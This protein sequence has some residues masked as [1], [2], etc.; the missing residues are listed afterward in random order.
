MEREILP[1]AFS[2][3]AFVLV[4]RPSVVR[5]Q[6]R[7]LLAQEWNIEL[8]GNPDFLDE[9]YES[10]GIDEARTLKE[11][12]VSHGFG[13]NKRVF[14]I[15]FNFI[16]RE[17]QNAL[18]KVFEEPTSDTCFFL[19]TSS[20][21]ALLP[22]LRSR[23]Q[24]M[25]LPENTEGEESGVDPKKFLAAA[26]GARLKMIAGFMKHENEHKKSDLLAL[27]SSLEQELAGQGKL[28]ALDTDGKTA[29][30]EMLE[31][32]NYLFDRSPSVKMIGEYLCV[33]LPIVVGENR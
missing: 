22:T 9:Q 17:A 18:L 14:V 25:R 32:K 7:E 2:H 33:R 20:L 5:P 16:T 10:F 27:I 26:P 12:Q 19:I 11:R 24:V 3:H 31:L 28:S 13:G 6:L 23:V 21:S 30:S 4:G 8:S 15:S 29:V 1:A